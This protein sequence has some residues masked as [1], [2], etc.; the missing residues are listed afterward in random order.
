MSHPETVRNFLR[1]QLEELSLIYEISV[2]ANVGT[3]GL[4]FLSE[5]IRCHPIRIERKPSPLRDLAAV[6]S[7]YLLFRRER[8]DAVHSMTPKAGLLADAGGIVCAGPD[9]LPYFY[10]RGVATRAGLARLLLKLMDGLTAR[11][12]TDV[13]NR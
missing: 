3:G 13:F 10:G 5:A 4:S 9:P 8:F 7:L 1:F 11:L 6:W 12:S 2:V